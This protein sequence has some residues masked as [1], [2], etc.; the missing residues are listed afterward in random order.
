MTA[1]LALLHDGP[2][3]NRERKFV[4]WASITAR[5]LAL[6]YG[7]F[8]LLNLVGGWLVP[9]F[10][11]NLW[12]LDLRLLPLAWA[13]AFMGLTALALLAFGVALPR[14]GVRRGLTILV[15]SALIFV[16]LVNSVQFYGLSLRG[17]IHAGWLPVSLLVTLAFIL[18]LRVALEEQPARGGLRAMTQALALCGLCLVAFP[19]AQ[20]LGFGRTDYRRPADVVVVPGARVY[21]DGRLSDALADRVR[22][23]CG[24]YKD[25]LAAKLIFSG[26]PGDGTIHETEA[27][28]RF[29]IGLGVLEGDIL[30]DSGGVNTQATV[31]H[32]DAM[33]AKLGAQ[34][35][36]VVS[37][38]YHLPRLKLAWHR[39]GREIFTV[40]AKEEY[41]LGRMPL[42]MAREVVALWA[43]YLRP[44]QFAPHSV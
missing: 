31:Q 30:L 8:A 18:I 29:A 9:G 34:R 22:T 42:Y 14:S 24:I 19:L 40:P 39:Q 20:M 33:C 11:A 36:L 16:S 7:G 21:A 6:F 32:V 13:Q 28:K 2:I 41:L 27:M 25:H 26:G 1:R 12:W 4:G 17:R 23:A 38:A 15:A 35:V 10:D 3:P 37:H 44:L 5:G 43:Y